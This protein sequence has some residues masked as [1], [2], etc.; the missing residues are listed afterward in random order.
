ME[1]QGSSISV[2]LV[3]NFTLDTKINIHQGRKIVH[4]SIGGSVAF[5][6]A[7]FAHF[8]P[9]SKVTIFTIGTPQTI[10]FLLPKLKI[11]NQLSHQ[12]S[13]SELTHFILKYQHNFRELVLKSWPSRKLSFPAGHSTLNYPDVIFLIPV[14]RELGIEQAEKFRFLYPDTLLVTDVQGWCRKRDEISGEISN[15][16]WIPS[17]SFL[18]SINIIKLSK[19]DFVNNKQNMFDLSFISRILASNTILIITLGKEGVMCWSQEKKSYGK[20]QCYFCPALDLLAS[21][22]VDQTGAGDIFLISFIY[23]Y[24]NESK[25]IPLALANGVINSTLLIQASGLNFKYESKSEI[26]ESI[27]KHI[28]KIEK[29]DWQEAYKIVLKRIS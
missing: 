22:I 23:S 26:L 15:H 16:E 18:Q 11:F 12:D 6:G 10:P 7:W 28:S 19:G 21:D 24:Y 3:G 1:N 2:W 27:K 25:D 13:N 9:T 20:I 29:L 5:A 14:Y 4:K 17:E 8:H